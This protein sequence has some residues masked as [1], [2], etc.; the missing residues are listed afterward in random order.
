MLENSACYFANSAR[1]LEELPYN[2]IYNHGTGDDHKKDSAGN[3]GRMVLQVGSIL[4]AI[5]PGE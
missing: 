5:T 2:C 4:L 3:D 1:N